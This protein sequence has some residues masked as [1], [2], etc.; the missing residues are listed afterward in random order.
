MKTMHYLALCILIFLS[1]CASKVQPNDP[2]PMHESFTLDSKLLGEKRI[3]NIW[4]PSEYSKNTTSYPVLYMADGGIK[5]D[6]P[7]LANTVAKLIKDKKIPAVILVGI[8]NTQRRRDLTG[9]TNVEED[10]KIAAVVGGSEQFRN[11]IKDELFPE[12]NAKYRTTSEKSIIGESLAGLFIMETFL[13]APEM[14]DNYI[15][16]DPSLWW[17]NHYLT[18]TAKDYLAKFPAGTKKKLWFASSKEPSTSEFT[19]Q[20]SQTLNSANIP[21]LKWNYSPAPTEEH[22]TVFRAVKEKALVWTLNRD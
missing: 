1:S 5:E 9:F 20:I 22:S 6:F 21:N 10:K 3:I 15:A 7:H 2:V 17:N 12:I 18:S 16:I 19:R 14:F 11:F 8:E 13:T 4:T